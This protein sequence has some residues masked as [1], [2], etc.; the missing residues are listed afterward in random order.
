MRFADYRN[1]HS[2][3]L[4][5]QDRHQIFVTLAQFD[6][7]YVN[8]IRDNVPGDRPTRLSFLQMKEYGPFGIDSSSHMDALGQLLL[9]F[10]LQLLEK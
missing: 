1:L 7:D 4:V 5:S 9:A 3:L 8:Y 2:R 6:S 10:C